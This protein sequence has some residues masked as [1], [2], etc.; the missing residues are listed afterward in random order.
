MAGINVNS[1]KQ[2]KKQLQNLNTAVKNLQNQNNSLANTWPK[3]LEQAAYAQNE[4]DMFNAEQAQINRDW[5]E[6][7]SSTAHQREVEDLKAAGLNPV[8]SANSS[9]AAVGSGAQ[10][11]S[12]N[13][14]TGVI[15]N[16]ASQAL[17]AVSTMS[18]QM[19]ALQ[20][21]LYENLMTNSTSRQNAITN[22]NASMYGSELS[23]QASIFA[24]K[25]SSQ[26][27]L[28][29][30]EANNQMNKYIAEL[31]AMNQQECARI[32]GEYN[33]SVAEV[34]QY[35]QKYAADISYLASLNSNKTNDKI[36]VRNSR[37]QI[38]TTLKN[39]AA[40]IG[41][42]HDNNQTSFIN[43]LISTGLGL[44]GDMIKVGIKKAI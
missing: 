36:S 29:I 22:A 38:L 33:I 10:A 3:M 44:A 26:T 19:A 31:N 25:L 24:S 40:N 42:A 27:N 7:M 4:A 6:M 17:N 43:N 16:I 28:S 11:S 14:L 34:Q 37:T 1:L 12:T 23:Y 13:A 2:Y 8:L 15:G 32:A 20:G 5:Q 39:N 18:T 9:G 41:I 30:A 35:T 21:S